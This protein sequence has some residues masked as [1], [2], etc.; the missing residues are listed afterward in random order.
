MALKQ[1]EHAKLECNPG[2]A[3]SQ[4]VCTTLSCSRFVLVAVINSSCRVLVA[5]GSIA[6]LYSNVACLV[7]PNMTAIQ[8]EHLATM[9]APRCHAADTVLQAI[10]DSSCGV[11]V[12]SSSTAWRSINVAC[13]AMPEITAM[14]DAADPAHLAAMSALSC[15]SRG[16]FSSTSAP[17][18]GM[19]LNTVLDSRVVGT[20]TRYDASQLRPTTQQG[21][22][23]L[24]F[25]LQHCLS[26][27][28][29]LHS[30]QQ[31]W[32]SRHCLMR[33]GVCHTM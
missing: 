30:H 9:H 13:L 21:N 11:F 29:P 31:C 4:H 18:C 2:R 8:A 1:C 22:A 6:L 12:A 16:V 5:R 32:P 19:L 24:H 23:Q 27:C 7:M 26:A 14:L 3:S 28:P 10:I 25:I 33:R 15:E 17:F 20:L